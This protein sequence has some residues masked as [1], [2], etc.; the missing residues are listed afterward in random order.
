M[1]KQY[2]EIT[3]W[4]VNPTARPAKNHTGFSWSLEGEMENSPAVQHPEK[5]LKERKRFVDCEQMANC[6][7]TTFTLISKD[8]VCHAVHWGPVFN[9][10]G[11]PVQATG[12]WAAVIVQYRESPTMKNGWGINQVTDWHSSSPNCST[13]KISWALGLR[14]EGWG[15]QDFKGS[16]REGKNGGLWISKNDLDASW[17]QNL[18]HPPRCNI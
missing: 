12:C 1:Q 6:E 3:S 13:K 7:Q 8:E 16:D 11:L 18:L 2:P 9:M 4:N 10:T 14:G 17:N 15:R 5:S